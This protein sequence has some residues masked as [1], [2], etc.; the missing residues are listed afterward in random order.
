VDIT[1]VLG[2][3]KVEDAV[4]GVTIVVTLLVF[5]GGVSLAKWGWTAWH[6]RSPMVGC[7]RCGRHIRLKHARTVR[8]TTHGVFDASE[9]VNYYCKEGCPHDPSEPTP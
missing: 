5:Q 3:I 8:G 4:T 6:N 7:S 1:D 9:A 2:K